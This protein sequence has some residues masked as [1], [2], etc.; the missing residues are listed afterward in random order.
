MDENE[1]KLLTQVGSGTPCGELMRRY[2][3]PAALSEELPDGGAPI[4]I[5]LLGEDLVL[6][7]D[8]EGRPGLLGLH[9]SHRG[10][11]LSYGRVEDGGLRCIYHGWLYDIRGNCL[12]Q[13]GEPGG[14]EHRNS[15][16]HTAYPCVEHVGVIF[17]YMGP[18]D[19]PLFPNYEFLRTPKERTFAIKLYSNCNYLQGNEGNIDLT[20]LSFL[21]YISSRREPVTVVGE[22]LSNRGAAPEMESYDAE[23]TGHGM[24]S[25]KIRQINNPDQYHLFMTE[26]VLPSFTCF[27]GGQYAAEGAYSVNW[28]VPID[29]GHHWKY[30]FVFSRKGPLD[31]ET[32]RRQRAEMTPDYKPIRHRDNRYQQDIE[33]MRSQSYSGIGMNFQVQDLCVTEGMGVI[34]DRPN[35]HLTSQDVSI[36]AARKVLLKAITDLQEGKEP[37]NVVR[38]PKANYFLLDACSDLVPHSQPWKE[39]VRSLEG[40]IQLQREG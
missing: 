37:T 40:R 25:Y 14:G 23:L 12:D 26:F 22:G 11:D 38:D 17:A 13:P 32:T 15:I 7:R 16:H 8:D 5:R 30:T 20:H 19:P 6:F 21:H 36:V 35:E 27:Y 9:C 3:Q 1:N 10:A 29:D 24:R 33:S 2:W 28:H 4:P 18:G 34:Q 39:Y 31:G